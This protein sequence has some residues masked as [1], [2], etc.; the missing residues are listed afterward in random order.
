[1]A[2]FSRCRGGSSSIASDRWPWAARARVPPARG[3]V[4]ATHHQLLDQLGRQLAAALIRW[5]R[6][7]QLIV[8]A[9][10]VVVGAWDLAN[11]LDLILA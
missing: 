8:G 2:S 9:G 1:M 4:A 3:R 6:P 7:F 10:L 11:N 5:E